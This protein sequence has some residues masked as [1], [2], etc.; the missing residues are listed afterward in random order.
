MKILE[1]PK[2]LSIHYI[3]GLKV[4]VTRTGAFESSF[5][6]YPHGMVAGCDAGPSGTLVLEAVKQTMRC[7]AYQGPGSFEV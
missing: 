5:G 6:L 4:V 1:S 2:L 3:P 7:S